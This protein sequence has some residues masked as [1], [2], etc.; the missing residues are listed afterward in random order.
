MSS[1]TISHSSSG[2]ESPFP[3]I[4]S[5]S[6]Y[7]YLTFAK[8]ML[9]N[10]NKLLKFHK[11]YFYCLDEKIYYALKNLSLENLENFMRQ[12][13]KTFYEKKFTKKRIAELQ[14]G[15]HIEVIVY[16]DEE[17][18]RILGPD[19][20]ITKHNVD[21]EAPPWLS[22]RKEITNNELQVEPPL[23]EGEPDMLRD[24]ED[25]ASAADDM[26]WWSDEQ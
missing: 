10:L 3:V 9:L 6:N 17:L 20:D 24:E 25:M 14:A 1:E 12:I 15:G 22:A 4:I 16:S 5:Y 26:P 19:Y 8:N 21:V 7:G 2:S 18:Q 13:R 23:V 11:V